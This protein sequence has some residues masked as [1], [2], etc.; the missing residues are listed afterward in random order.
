M[1][2]SDKKAMIEAIRKLV[3]ESQEA[4]PGSDDGGKPMRSAVI[5]GTLASRIHRVIV[6]LPFK[7]LFFLALTYLA[8]RLADIT[9]EIIRNRNLIMRIR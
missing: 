5:I 9:L 4:Y 8:L 7:I 2:S 1:S 6:S 3:E